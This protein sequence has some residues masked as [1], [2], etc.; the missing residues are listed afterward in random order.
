MTEAAGRGRFEAACVALSDAGWGRGATAGISSGFVL[1]GLGIGVLAGGSVFLWT[2]M[3]ASSDEDEDELARASPVVDDA[4]SK[5]G[6]A[7]P[8][9]RRLKAKFFPFPS[10]MSFFGIVGADVLGAETGCFS[11]D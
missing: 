9:F 6:S 11:G 7:K 8:L 5:A 2:W 4:R 3:T 1:S 10:S